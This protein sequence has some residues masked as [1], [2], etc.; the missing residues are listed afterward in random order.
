M[1]NLLKLLFVAG[2]PALAGSCR[3]YYYMPNTPLMPAFQNRHDAVLNVGLCDQSGTEIQAAYSPLKYTAVLLNHMSIDR[4]FST[5]DEWA[6]GRLTEGGFGFY[7]GKHPWSL[8]L[9]GGYGGGF[10]EN[11]YG[12]LPGNGNGYAKSRLKL[13]QYFIQPGFVLQSPH[14]KLGLVLRHVWL[15]Y[16]KGDTD[17]LS[18][19]QDELNA[20]KAIEERTPFNFSE[21]GVTLGFRFRPFTI[22]YNVVSIIDTRST[23]R[24]LHFK[25]G[26]RSIMVTLALNELWQKK[27]TPGSTPENK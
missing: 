14:L 16:Y 23:Y 15:H 2:L 3:H 18:I 27:E 8:H 17:V 5:Q 4:K 7:Y 12:L 13:E 22:S 24:D 11:G 26:N 21:L 19:D 9:L 6:K 1:K 20:L 10:V 25:N